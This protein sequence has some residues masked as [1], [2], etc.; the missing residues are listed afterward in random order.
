MDGETPAERVG[1]EACAP[2]VVSVLD[3]PAQAWVTLIVGLIAIAG[4]LITWRQ[5]NTADRRSEWWRRLA[6]AYERAFSDDPAEQELGWELINV[7]VAS[8]LATKDDSD[9]VQ[10]VGEL[11]ARSAAAEEG[12][13]GEAAV[14]LEEPSGDQDDENPAGRQDL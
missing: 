8:P 2:W 1:G 7:L 13:D 14:A 6:W 5:K 4:V 9:I 10:V 3:M 11:I 12:D